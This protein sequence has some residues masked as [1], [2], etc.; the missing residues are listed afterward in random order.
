[1][2]NIVVVSD[3]AIEDDIGVVAAVVAG[4]V[5]GRGVLSNVGALL[6]VMFLLLLVLIV[7]VDLDIDLV[8]GDV[9]VIDDES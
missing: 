3:D 4:D 1:M 8:A 7:S 5:S 9:V 2:L 6:L